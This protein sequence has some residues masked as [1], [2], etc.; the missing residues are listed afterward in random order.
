MNSSIETEEKEPTLKT[1]SSVKR[2]VREIGRTL[3]LFFCIFV[4]AFCLYLSFPKPGYAWVA[5]VA[6][7]PFAWG[8]VKVRRFWSSVFYAWLVG[9]LF[10]ALSLIWVYYTCLN[11]GGLSVE[12]S[13][14]AWLGLSGLLALQMALFG[15]SCYFLKKT[16]VFFPILA[17][18]GWVA[19]EWAHQTIAFYGI[20]FPWF[21]LGGS[22]WNFPEMLQLVSITGVYGLSFCL[23]WVGT[24][25]GWALTNPSVKKLV[26]SLLLAVV[27]A[28]SIYGFGHYRLEHFEQ[29]RKH[30][31]LL[32]LQAVLMQPNIDQYKKWDEAYEQEIM[33]VLA[34]M[35]EQ[36]SSSNAVLTVWPE[37]T[38]PGPLQEEKYAT[39]FRNLANTSHSY[40]LVGSVV[41][42][43]KQEQYVGAYLV[44]PDSENWQ[45]YRKVK[46]VPFGEFI[47][48]ASG[49]QS[50]FPDMDVLVE[51][52][53]FTPGPTSQELLN[54]QG[55]LLGSTIC[56]ESIFPQL[57][58]AQARKG[59]KVF[60]NVTN[61]AWFFATAAPYQH[62]SA[63]VLH[64]VETGR[65]VLR[66]ANTGFSAVI[67]PVGKIE[68]K[69]G[70]FSREIL[71][72]AVALPVGEYQTFYTQWGD[73]FAWVCALLFFTLLISTIVFAYE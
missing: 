27:I 46:L 71:Y 17:A 20:G 1:T 4:T 72:S 5:W 39:L 41:P 13:L 3:F 37:S 64:A 24:Q 32:S 56:Y 19:F 59:A 50:L 8:I 69:S 2:I 62:L 38:T 29:I 23:V 21:M 22:Q 65:S 49:V 7:V 36:V 44:G 43:T 51:L 63:N 48:F 15:G 16:G 40:Q 68:D 61:D 11:G 52:G 54:L 25:L 35:G 12:L 26:G 55:V 66:A 67:N 31:S 9:F 34:S 58:V 30:Q 47:P 33:D 10:H 57:W 70:L 42:G 6:F 45:E 14:A 28:S 18:C 53:A 60:V 73:W